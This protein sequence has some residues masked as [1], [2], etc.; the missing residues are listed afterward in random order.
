MIKYN[1]YVGWRS[2]FG[3]S[4]PLQDKYTSFSVVGSSLPVKGRV[5]RQPTYLTLTPNPVAFDSLALLFVPS[6]ARESTEA[7]LASRWQ[8]G[9]EHAASPLLAFLQGM[10]AQQLC[11]RM[12]AGMALPP[13]CAVDALRDS[14]S[15]LTDKVGGLVLVRLGWVELGLVWLGR[16]ELGV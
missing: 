16:V 14:F 12:V 13:A 8:A 3:P 7:M 11:L 6:G 15:G 1:T 9:L 4:R 2:S 10:G 5:C